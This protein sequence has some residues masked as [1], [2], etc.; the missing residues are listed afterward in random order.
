MYAYPITVHKLCSRGAA[1]FDKLPRDI[2]NQLHLMSTC[3]PSSHL[4]SA[5][6]E[7]QFEMDL[8]SKVE[9][10]SARNICTSPAHIMRPPCLT[11]WWR[12][13]GTSGGG[14]AGCDKIWVMRASSFWASAFGSPIPM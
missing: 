6:F 13:W 9:E 2:K 14:T 4:S 11:T 3:E 5:K 8:I 12:C 7:R 1:H 10:T